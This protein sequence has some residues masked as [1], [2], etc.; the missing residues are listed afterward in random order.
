MKWVLGIFRDQGLEGKVSGTLQIGTI[1]TI[2]RHS[3]PILWHFY[4]DFHF[5][6]EK[7]SEPHVTR[8][9][10]ELL[11]LGTSPSLRAKRMRNE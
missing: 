10:S 9:G 11:W 3:W 8:V 5:I 6:A 7:A 1:G 2:G 4:R